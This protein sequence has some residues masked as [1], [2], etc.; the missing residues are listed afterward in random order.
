MTN[1]SCQALGIDVPALEAVKD[2][3]EANS[4]ALL[5]VALLERGDA[6]T[7]REVAERFA[8]A[9]VAPA[10]QAL[11]ALQRCRPARPPV[12]RNGDHYALDPH[13]DDLK[14]WPVRLDLHPP[15]VPKLRLIAREPEPLA[16]PTEPLTVAE[17]DEA[18]RDAS[19]YGWSAQRLALAVLDA[20]GG[21]MPPHEVVAF[22]SARGEE[23]L[24]SVDSASHWRRGAAVRVGEDGRWQLDPQHKALMS[25]RK[26]VRARIAMVRRR[27]A[28][29]PDPAESQARLRR[30]QQ[31][32]AARAAEL[33]KLR[34]V[35]V[36]A[37][38]AFPA[39]PAKAP[40]AVVIV[41]VGDRCLETFLDDRLDEARRLIASSDVVGALDV[42]GSLAALGVD[43]GRHRLDAENHDRH[44]HSRFLP[45]RRSLLRCGET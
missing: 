37:F 44:A 33:E 28:M 26:A 27:A 34:R 38:P 15:K 25:A 36:H 22:V 16:G 10:D 9:G 39:F 18:W 3:R 43:A 14:F 21:P 13:D 5:I 40:R 32:R 6:M 11:R 45:D 7:L 4:Y 31:E 24:L 17:L 23:H 8:A 35:L 2:H 41:N 1:S 42:R 29:Q 19:L 20:H 30:W 12:Y